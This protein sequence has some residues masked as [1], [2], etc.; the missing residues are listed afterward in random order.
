MTRVLLHALPFGGEMW[1]AIARPSDLCPDL[2]EFG[3]TL[4]AWADAVLDLVPSGPLT[5]IGNSVGGSCAIEIAARAPGRIEQLVLI[6]AKAGHAPDPKLRD[7]AL[8]MLADD[9]LA[10]AWERYWQPLFASS[11]AAIVESARR[12]AFSHGPDAIARGVR[13][14]HSR[15]DRAEWLRRFERRVIVVEGEHD[16]PERGRAIAETARLAT[17]VVVPGAGHFVPL[18]APNELQQILG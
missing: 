15:P 9:G 4:E 10:P 3:D 1:H 5:L 2:Y 8:R 16:R 13:A 11:S 7:A 14:F 17:F 6:G 18:E 12:A